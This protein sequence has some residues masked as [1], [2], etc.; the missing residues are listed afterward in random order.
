MVKICRVIRIKLNQLVPENVRTIAILL[1]KWR[2]LTSEQQTFRRA[3]PTKWRK[4]ADMKKVRH[5][6]PMYRHAAHRK[7]RCINGVV[8]AR[9]YLSVKCWR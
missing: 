1:R 4:T 2:L 7:G 5:C 6:H 9:W 8:H 3:C